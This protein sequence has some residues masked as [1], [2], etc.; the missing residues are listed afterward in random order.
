MVMELFEFF[1]GLATIHQLSELVESFNNLGNGAKNLLSVIGVLTIILGVLQCFFGYKL[2]KIWCGFIG[3]LAGCIIGLII[4][5]TGVF[6]GT[7]AEYIIAIIVITLLGITGAFLA[8]RAY[9]IGLFVYS[10]VTAFSAVFTLMAF[11]TNA[12][13]VGLIVG[14]VT[15]LVF[16]IV[17][18]KFRRFWIIV[19]TSIAGGISIAV[20]LMMIF[21]RTDSLWALVLPPVFIVAGFIVQNMT[22]KKEHGKNDNKGVAVTAEASD[23][24]GSSIND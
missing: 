3:L 4:A 23:K 17:A 6:A 16:G 22:T 13:I 10:F 20:S 21:Q 12:V 5:A 8:Y 11:I 9:L 24:Q 1:L 18:V 15:G 19:T 2:F 7:G 14:A